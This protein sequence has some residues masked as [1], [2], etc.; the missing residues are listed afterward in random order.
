V[1]L[2]LLQNGADPDSQDEVCLEK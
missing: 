2:Q 1:V